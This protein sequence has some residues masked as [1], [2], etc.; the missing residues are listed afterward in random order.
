M[1]DLDSQ[2]LKTRITLSMKKQ[3]KL[4]KRKKKMLYSLLSFSEIN[5]LM[6]FFYCSFFEFSL[7]YHYKYKIQRNIK[8]I[9]GIPNLKRMP[10]GGKYID[11]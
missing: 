11:L 8:S 2:D 4:G 9:V 6:P 7:G 3:V 1:N 10:F 5:D